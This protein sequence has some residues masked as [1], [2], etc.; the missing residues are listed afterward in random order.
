[1]KPGFILII[2]TLMVCFSFGSALGGETKKQCPD[3]NFKYENA[4]G[5]EYWEWF[6]R[7]HV[8]D[9]VQGDKYIC[10]KYSEPGE[11]APYSGDFLVSK[12]EIEDRQK[13]EAG[14]KRGIIT[15]FGRYG[16]KK[17]YPVFASRM[18]VIT[19]LKFETA[20]EW[21]D[22]WK[23]NKDRLVLSRDGKYLVVKKSE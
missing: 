14:L 7:G 12:I 15:L 4:S 8:S 6:A 5:K 18:E 10:A 2:G 11:H 22:W 9:L 19:G 3:P 16:H 20:K 1:M 13:K 17:L 23:T 21:F